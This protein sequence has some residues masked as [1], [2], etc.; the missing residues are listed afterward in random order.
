MLRAWKA[1]HESAWWK[2]R[3]QRPG[4]HSH[5]H[6]NDSLIRR[7]DGFLPCAVSKSALG[8][9]VWSI[10][11]IGGAGGFHQSARMLSCSQRSRPSKLAVPPPCPGSIAQV[12]S[13]P[14]EVT[15]GRDQLAS[16]KPLP[17]KASRDRRRQTREVRMLCLRCSASIVSCT[18][19]HVPCVVNISGRT[20]TRSK[21]SLR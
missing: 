11:T 2:A 4:Y 15:H 14:A 3:P 17:L 13:R 7:S 19:I 16:G 18:S 21:R 20:L 12:V 5:L 6:G 10:S 1:A 8:D 9:A